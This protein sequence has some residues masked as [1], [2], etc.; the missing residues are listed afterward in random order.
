MLQ[1]L[2]VVTPPSKFYTVSNVLFHKDGGAN[3]AVTNCM[4]H[5]YMFVPTKSTVKLANGNTVH[6][7]GIGIILFRFPNC[8]IIYLVRPVYYCPF[9]HSNTISSG[10][11][12]F[13][14]GF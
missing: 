13:Y 1:A 6:A 12:K 14:I 4:S 7:Q 11:L 8:S 5:F 2:L 10:A 3:V 9:H